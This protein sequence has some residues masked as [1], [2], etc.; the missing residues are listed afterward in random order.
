[1]S[2]SAQSDNSNNTGSLS[3]QYIS[4]YDNNLNSR[5]WVPTS[6]K[7]SRG[8]KDIVQ[9]MFAGEPMKNMCNV[10]V[11]DQTTESWFHEHTILG[12]PNRRGPKLY[13][14]ADMDYNAASGSGYTLD[15]ITYYTSASINTP[16]SWA[17][18]GTN[19]SHSYDYW[20]TE[21]LNNNVI[22]YPRY[23]PA[24]WSGGTWVPGTYVGSTSLGGYSG[25]WIKIQV[26][27]PVQ[28]TVF[29]LL[30][31][32]IEHRFPETW[33]ILGSNNDINWTSLGS[34]S[35][36][37]QWSHGYPI[38]NNLTINTTYSYF[39]I[40]FTQRHE[41]SSN[42]WH[43]GE[44]ICLEIFDMYFYT[45][46]P[47]EDFGRSLDGTDNAD[48]VAIGA[49]GTWF[50][51]VSNIN[52]YARVFTKNSSGNG[53]TQRGSEVSQQGGF[54]HSVAL[55][56]H[57]GNILVVGAPFYNTLVPNSSGATQFHNMPVSE[58]KVY[59]YKWN[60]KNPGDYQLEQ[61]LSPPSGSLSTTTTPG[62][63]QNFYFG[64]SLGITD[65]GDKIIVGEPSIRNIWTHE[66]NLQGGPNNSWATNSFPYTGN[67]HVYENTSLL[68]GGTNWTRNISITSVVG[69]T[70]IGSS[71]YHPTKVRW[72]D[73]LGTSVD[74]NRAGTRILAG[75][76]GNYG[77]SSSAPQQFM[78]RVYTLDWNNQ[79]NA[80]E[81]MGA[82]GK[83]ISPNQ[84]EMMFGWC[85]RFDGSGN[86]I[87]SGAPGY[88]GH[89]LY[90]KGNVVVYT[91]NGEHWVV[92]PNDTVDITGW[93]VNS[94]YWTSYNH[95]LG[96]SI[97][98]D[99]EGEWVSL[100]KYETHKPHGTPPS[101]GFRPN[102]FNVDNITYIGGA[103]TTVAGSNSD[104]NT[105][106][107]NIWTYYIVQSMVVKGNVSVGGI[108][109]GTGVCIGTN[110]DSSTSNKSI[111]F[112][113]TKSDNS[114]QLTVI[115][116]RVYQT[117]EKAELL[118][119]KGNDNADASGGGTYG[120]DRIRLKA[121]QIAFDLNTGTNRMDEDIR[122]V[123]HR[124]AGG[125]GMLGINVS[126]PTE[127]VHV[128]GKIKCTQG[129]V[130]RGK[131]ITG[132]DFDYINNNNV[133]KFGSP[134]VTQSSTSWGT[135]PVGSALAYPTVT[136]TSNTSSGYTVT[137]SRDVTNAYTVF[138]SGR[139]QIGTAEVYSNGA[140]RGGYLGSTERIS[141]Y[142]GEWIELRIPNKIYLTRLDVDSDYFYAPRI[143]HVFGSNDGIEY[144]LIHYSGDLGYLWTGQSGN[145]TIFT[146]TPDYIND[147][148][149]DRILIIVNMISG[150]NVM[151]WDQ[152]DIF[153]TSATFT[154]KVHIDNSGKIGI[155]NTNPFYQLDVTG[156]INLTGDL[157]INGVAQTFGGGGGGGGSSIWGL[158][159]PHAFYLAGN[160]GIG[161]NSPGAPLEV[162]SSGGSNPATN[163]ILVY[164]NS[165]TTNEDSILTL[166]VGGSSAGDP[167]LSFDSENEAGWAFGMDNS[168]SNKMK[169]STS[170]SSVS[171][172]TKLTIDTSGKVG[173]GTTTPTSLLHV[174]GD[175]NLTGPFKISGST[176]T[177]GQV[178]TS[179]GGSQMVWAVPGS[180]WGSNAQTFP[181]G[182]M[183]S[184]FSGQNIVAA[185]SINSSSEDPWYAFNHTISNEGWL[186]GSG[187][188]S[189]GVYNSTT[190]T[191]Y[192][193]NSIEYG[194]WI[195]F[196]FPTG[197]AI[198]E[199]KIAPRTGHLDKCVGEGRLLGSNS[200]AAF[201]N[202]AFFTG[203]TY[204]T[205]NYTSIKFTAAPSYNIFRL[206]VT[207]LS[208][209]LSTSNQLSIGEIQFKEI[210]DT[211]KAAGK[212]GIGTTAPSYTLDVDGD[213]NMSTG[214]SFRINGVA[215]T[216]GGGGG[217]SSVWSTS[218]SDVYRS[219]GKVGIGITS[220]GAPLEVISSGGSNPE[221][222]GIL[223]YNSTNSSGEDSILALRVGGSSAGDAYLSFDVKNEAGWAFGMDNSDSNK[224][225]LSSSW[226]SLSTNTKLTIDTSGK[227]GIGTTS[228][229]YMLDVNGDIN[230]S[231]GSSF[232]INGVAQT[233]G[234]GGGSSP[235]TTGS[236][237]G[238]YPPNA[239]VSNG[240]GG[241]GSTASSSA[242]T[243]TFDTFKAF[244]HVIGN[245]GWHGTGGEYYNVNGA[246]IGSYSTTY[247]GSSIVY[248][249]WIQLE[250]PSNT[251]INE[252]EIAPRS[253]AANYL[254]RCP[255]DGRIL[256]STNG[257]TWTSVATFSGKT[258]TAAN[259][260]SITFNVSSP[261]KFF[262][263]V[264]TQLSGIGESV[265]NIGE[266]R[267]KGGSS[268]YYPSSGSGLVGIGTTS[269]SYALDVNGD[270]NM[271]TG[272]SF[273]INGV[274]QTFGSGGGGSSAWTT[275]GNDLYWNGSG[276][277]SIGT[278]SVF[279]Q[280]KFYINGYVS[281]YLS[282]GWH[283]ASGGGG[284]ASGT[285]EYSIYTSDRI[286][287]TEFNA[288][289]DIRIKK[290]VVDIN[291]SSALDKIRL[292]EPKIYNYI[293][294]K[295]KGTSN[296]Y[297]FI[298]QQ[299][300]NVLPYAV[301]V[302]EG[303]IPNILTNS[304]VVINENNN[305]VELRLDIPVEGLSL[306]NTSN[307]NIITDK[308][309]FVTCPVISSSGSNVITIS[310]T[311]NYFSN[312][313]GA[314][315][316]GERIKDFH[317]LNKDAIWAV[318]T[319]ALQEVDRQ[320]Q[321][322]KTK[323]ATLET[324]VADLLARVTALENT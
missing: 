169:L 80:W 190:S 290:N 248:G 203:K 227:V 99:G 121:G 180:E 42:F 29:K 209:T 239:M 313:T 48:M 120:P 147:D 35:M 7:L 294:D 103:S 133:I 231:T 237:S 251:S 204:T 97:S 221:N 14:P 303:D 106:M 154:P 57:D 242:Y 31:D 144:D 153:G 234:G 36:P 192:G 88:M 165:N 114:Y 271:S 167:F 123:M 289:S 208:D 307:I 299:V 6:S 269:P 270:I 146:R 17:A 149:Y 28:P 155:V 126:S 62:S 306:S 130:G 218:G 132:L 125:A 4:D 104:I 322:E 300:S 41:I 254:N 268:I 136:L 286:A 265:V 312:V 187:K 162:I 321:A 246:Y 314:Y 189:F 68:A 118:L 150:G 56:Q 8:K 206:V 51:S 83:H 24:G 33:T 151:Y 20:S 38:I 222:N 247:N 135:L 213:I 207:K 285:N 279:N 52:G 134:G 288:F 109:Q 119:F 276:G 78:G 82:E 53:W 212:V 116:N 111:F 261:Y 13:P 74:I 44:L 92:F 216:F 181:T 223:V 228:P 274:A 262:R 157:R 267:F 256:G 59:I 23:Q 179:T 127:C 108:V 58:G 45:E 79:T 27:T 63:W 195:Q 191:Q 1:M 233:F 310:D 145:R 201:V 250:F 175:M 34:F 50:G 129:F 86:R 84:S 12:D 30:T 260:T 229:G 152:V 10:F 139:W 138:G 90:N 161:T 87:I 100:G 101:G 278:T 292:I 148:P 197:I 158:N 93:N 173:I 15:G 323:V 176:G 205:G 264:I 18:F 73:A 253:G 304:N 131:E 40:V 225:K 293:D 301:T 185:S 230:M 324:Q 122:C 298:A 320:L 244:N 215:Q 91:W 60:D 219:S 70:G 172:N 177:Y 305:T 107:S 258:Y 220:P 226:S 282:Y 143:A 95:R 275:S 245:E 140:N 316:H 214:S 37:Q 182:P 309:E 25:E 115:E 113:G 54:G 22:H 287:A 235:W 19:S 39:A 64:Y 184:N 85:T 21:D 124:N 163:G 302:G 32:G 159:T 5:Y 259:Y 273:R 3:T 277:V 194:E 11:Y 284:Q 110:D 128:D 2:G 156:D 171:T 142:K 308:D 283:N 296:V 9:R 210:G 178:L 196:Q 199:I 319:A 193:S 243:P 232:R 75:A 67:A 249:E 200:G 94:S 236:S 315:I 238:T 98:V 76:P 69:V 160:V 240:S 61:T 295:R 65:I 280:A 102:A 89:M 47:S 183:T 55:S 198:D 188:Y 186:S 263:V 141:G 164:N 49:P 297:G 66:D 252:V 224:M 211:Y 117:E 71:D 255:G 241:Y 96:E 257:S 105:G 26:S 72:L 202:I 168:D 318:S 112:G 272:S 311:N 317:H 16:E 217:G 43:P 137:A 281:R 170:W 46:D 266:L 81:E 77:T 291:D 166:R 174:D